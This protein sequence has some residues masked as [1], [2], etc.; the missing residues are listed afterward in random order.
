MRVNWLS[1]PENSSQIHTVRQAAEC[2]VFGAGLRRGK[3]GRKGKCTAGSLGYQWEGQL[4]AAAEQ[5]SFICLVLSHHRGKTMS[6]TG[7]CSRDISGGGQL[8]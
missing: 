6:K 8:T 2:W 7:T 5:L 4:G 3:V 1:F